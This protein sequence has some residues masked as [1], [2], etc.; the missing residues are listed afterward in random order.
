MEKKVDKIASFV[1][2]NSAIQFLD[3][4]HTELKLFVDSSDV[5]TMLQGI[6]NMVDE[7]Q[8]L[9]FNKYYSTST[10]IYSLIYNQ[11]LGKVTLAL[12]HQEEL[13]TNLNG[14]EWSFQRLKMI[15]WRNFG[16]R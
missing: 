2:L 15:L 3:D 7:N 16:R 8:H 6:R 4:Q 12:P 1:N 11:W 14:G 9:H 13:L 5:L 10:L